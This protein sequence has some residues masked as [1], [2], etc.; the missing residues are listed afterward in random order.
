MP[1][2]Q[3]MSDVIVLIPGILGSV[4]V[5]KNGTELWGAS[6][7]SIA[8][9]LL[10]FGKALNA[11]ALPQGIGHGD[12]EDG[13]TTPR[14]L[15]S[16]YMVPTFWKADGYGRLVQHLKERF[17][18]TPATD[19]QAGNLLEFPYDWRLSNQLNAQRL[20]DKVVPLLERWRQSS[21]NPNAKLIFICH[22][23][24][25]LVARY[26]LEALGGRDLTSKLI[27]IGTPYRGSIGALDALVNGLVLGLGPIGVSV[28][29]LVRSFPSTY[30]LLPT[31]DC[32]DVGDGE[33]RKLNGSD[34]PNVDKKDV[35]EA[36][37]F[38]SRIAD[39]IETNP[40]YETF[41]IKGI[42]QPANRASFAMAKSSRCAATKAKT[43]LAT[44]LC[45]GL[46][47]IHPNGLTRDHRCSRL[48]H[49][50]CC[51]QPTLFSHRFSA[52]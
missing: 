26:F 36:L 32:L 17:T 12:P 31:Y 3:P 48:N 23:M 37:A 44:A 38:H 15:P 47:R 11:L 27:T 29:K 49:T 28:D 43:S 8:R 34:L 2:Q 22:S 19:G 5:D 30:Q 52:C 35:A 6:G 42:D 25:G 20:S 1:Q 46:L 51:N 10:T 13:V 9:N 14:V 24:G 40:R 21:N 50:Q 18:L 7:S 41:A 39:A 16:L 45:R 33:L 4:L